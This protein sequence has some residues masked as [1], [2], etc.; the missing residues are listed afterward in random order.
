MNKVMYSFSEVT[1][2]PGW[3]LGDAVEKYI[4]QRERLIK[5]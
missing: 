3:G 2:I 1:S 4:F 5:K